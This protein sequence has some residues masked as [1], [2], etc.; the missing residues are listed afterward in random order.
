MSDLNFSTTKKEN[1]VTIDDDPFVI[2]EASGG[3]A[4]EYH[5]MALN[6]VT[7]GADGKPTKMIGQASVQVLLV[8]KCLYRIDPKTELVSREPV[9]TTWVERNLP[10]K[11][12]KA[13]FKVA[14]DLSDLGEDQTEDDVKKEIK[15]LEDKL[16]EM[17]TD[18]EGEPIDD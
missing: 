2:R 4:V 6:G 9:G 16:I 17:E 15:K 18:S 3:T 13:L 7:F 11:V 10:A 12:M 14:N 1:A 5:N 8:G